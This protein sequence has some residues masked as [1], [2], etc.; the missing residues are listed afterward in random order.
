MRAADGAFPPDFL[1]GGATSARQ[2]GINV[3]HPAAD[4]ALASDMGFSVVRVAIPWSRIFPNG[5][6]DTPDEEGLEFYD[7]ALDECATHGIEPLVTVSPHEAPPN[8]TRRYGGWVNRELLTFYERYVR[9]VFER[10]RGKVTYWLNSSEGGP[11]MFAQLPAARV[12]GVSELLGQ[13]DLVQA[14]HHELVASA[15]ATRIAHDM[16]RGSQVG[17]LV[18]APS[19]YA[20]PPDPVGTVA[21]MDA[22]HRNLMP[23][24]VHNGGAYPSYALQ[25]LRENGMGLDITAEDRDILTNTVDFIAVSYSGSTREAGCHFG[26]RRL[27]AV[28]SQF[29]N[30]WHRPLFVIANDF[31][32]DEYVIALD[33][34]GNV[35]DYHLSQVGEAIADGVQVMGFISGSTHRPGLQRGTAR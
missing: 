9:T 15:L 33:G 24:D 23:S 10:Y 5:D 3:T 35:D 1:W 26:H 21:V 16:L 14:A 13:R 28:L 6:D 27:G 4:I 20:L 30:R 7:R 29:W 34:A 32:G 12:G 18:V 22:G 19:I 11:S 2:V 8:L 17:C 31:R 25:Y